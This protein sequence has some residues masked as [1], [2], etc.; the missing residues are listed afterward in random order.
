MN[1]FGRWLASALTLTLGLELTGLTAQGAVVWR[2]DFE[3]DNLAKWTAADPA[4]SV[5]ASTQAAYAGSRGGDVQGPTSLAGDALY[6]EFSTVDSNLVSLGLMK[7]VRS[8]TEAS[9]HWLVQWTPDRVDWLTLADQSAE[10]VDAEWVKY[11]WFLP[12]AATSKPLFAFRLVFI[13]DSASDRVAVDEVVLDLLPV[14][15]PASVVI[16]AFFTAWLAN[17]RR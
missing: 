7:K 5:V 1:K 10:S 2:E 12:F 4:W 8:S 14:P 3:S 9:D 11:Q 16:F 17:K 6:K 13:G 15:E